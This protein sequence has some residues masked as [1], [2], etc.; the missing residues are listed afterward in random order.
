MRCSAGSAEPAGLKLPDGPSPSTWSP[1]SAIAARR[2]QRRNDTCRARCRTRR[3]RCCSCPESDPS[4]PRAS[5][6]VSDHSTGFPATTASRPAAAPRPSRSPPVTSHATVSPVPSTG[7]STTPYT[8]SRSARSAVTPSTGSTASA[9]AQQAKDTAKPCDTCK[10]DSPRSSVAISQPIST[11]QHPPRRDREELRID[12]PLPPEINHQRPGLTLVSPT[13]SPY[14]ANGLPCLPGHRAVAGP[15]RRPPRTRAA[16]TTRSP[17]S[18][19]Y[20]PARA[21]REQ[22]AN[23]RDCPARRRCS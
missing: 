18:R 10:G 11:L 21:L 2:S 23:D 6:V 3:R 22:H 14:A 20:E 4:W 17:F 5:L 13:S 9:N 19:P 15:A 1:K 7:S 8:S 12:H 16:S